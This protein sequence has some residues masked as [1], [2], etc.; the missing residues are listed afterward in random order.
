[1]SAHSRPG[2]TLQLVAPANLISTK[3]NSWLW[4]VMARGTTAHVCQAS[5]SRMSFA[6][7]H[8][9][10]PASSTP[11]IAA[12]GRVTVTVTAS[13]CAR[14]RMKLSHH[15]PL[16]GSIQGRSL[17]APWAWQ[18][19]PVKLGEEQREGQV[20]WREGRGAWWEVAQV[21]AVA[22]GEWGSWLPQQT[23]IGACPCPQSHPHGLRQGVSCPHRHDHVPYVP[24]CTHSSQHMSAP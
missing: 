12:S 9:D 24:L 6:R 8:L 11:D 16:G 3:G 18:Q 17:A 2:T 22:W 4:T 21:G 19:G 1:M 7:W 23:S 5:K 20:W 14:P 13:Y 15:D 10:Q